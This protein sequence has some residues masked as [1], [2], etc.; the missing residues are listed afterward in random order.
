MTLR[1]T[2]TYGVCESC[3]KNCHQEHKM[4][5]E[6]LIDTNEEEKKVEEEVLV[7]GAEPVAVKR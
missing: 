6:F 3:L 7:P 5:K 4:S 1:R 2:W